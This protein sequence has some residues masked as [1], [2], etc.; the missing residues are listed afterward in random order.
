MQP[1]FGAWY[2]YGN[3]QTVT[4]HRCKPNDTLFHT[5]PEARK[6]A[7]NN[8]KKTNKALQE[9]EKYRF[10]CRACIQMDSKGVE[11]SEDNESPE[12]SQILTYSCAIKMVDLIEPPRWLNGKV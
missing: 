11:D 2:I 9:E 6:R 1:S 5:F 4:L 12:V 8:I 10:T 3:R 7:P